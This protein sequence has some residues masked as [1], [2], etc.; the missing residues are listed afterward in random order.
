MYLF[1]LHFDFVDGG[2]SATIGASGT[3]VSINQKV[4]GVCQSISASNV[5]SYP[6]APVFLFKKAMAFRIQYI[7]LP[8]F[9][10]LNSANFKVLSPSIMLETNYEISVE[11][12]LNPEQSFTNDCLF[13]G[14]T[15]IQPVYTGIVRGHQKS[16]SGSINIWHHFKEIV[17]LPVWS[18]DSQIVIVTKPLP[19]TYTSPEPE[20][21]DNLELDV[22]SLQHE[23][24]T[25]ASYLPRRK[26]RGKSILYEFLRALIFFQVSL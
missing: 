26:L 2:K 8:R 15:S 18:R 3:I 7:N 9:A 19:L 22:R 17:K 21:S 13:N 16:S 10:E 24:T 5:T 14:S 6:T 23:L 12:Y 25:S 1:I 4:D 11:Y 20:M